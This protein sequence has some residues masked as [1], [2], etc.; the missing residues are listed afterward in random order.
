MQP[1]QLSSSARNMVSSGNTDLGAD[2]D[3]TKSIFM[4]AAPSKLG[5]SPPNPNP[6]HPPSKGHTS[7]SNVSSSSHKNTAHGAAKV[8]QTTAQATFVQLLDMYACKNISS[9][10]GRGGGGDEK[11]EIKEADDLE[12]NLL[13]PPTGQLSE[14]MQ[15]S[16][17]LLKEKV[18]GF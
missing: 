2:A 9:D 3:T 4:T 10:N 15:R 5:S 7:S 12:S 8:A 11:G 13:S 17:I 16:D 14:R 18:A 6:N 1:G